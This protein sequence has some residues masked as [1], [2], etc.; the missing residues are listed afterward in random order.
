MRCCKVQ[1]FRHCCTN[2]RLHKPTHVRKARQ[3]PTLSAETM[4]FLFWAGFCLS[5]FEHSKWLLTLGRTIVD[6]GK[7]PIAVFRGA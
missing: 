5:D 1:D 2:W 4:D 7:C 6:V 3:L